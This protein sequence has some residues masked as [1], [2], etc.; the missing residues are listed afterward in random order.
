MSTR[1]PI[2]ASLWLWPAPKKSI[3]KN[4]KCKHYAPTH[5]HRVLSPRFIIHIVFVLASK[6]GECFLHAS[7]CRWS[8]ALNAA[9]FKSKT[10]F[11]SVQFNSDEESLGQLYNV[12]F[13]FEKWTEKA[14]RKYWAYFV[15]RKK[16]PPS[17]QLHLVEWWEKVHE[18][19][20]HKNQWMINVEC[21][22]KSPSCE[23]I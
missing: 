13:L 7:W 9:V 8:F 22:R 12:I 14:Y 4:A 16:R 21:A 10:S 1:N 19:R 11:S 15:A 18:R 2:C 17:G 20:V 5:C 23:I 6:L 3:A